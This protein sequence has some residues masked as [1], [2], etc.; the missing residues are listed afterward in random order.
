MANLHVGA[1]TPLLLSITPKLAEC[2]PYLRLPTEPRTLWVD[3]ICINQQDLEERKHQV[4]R[5]ANIYKMAKRVVVWLGPRENDSTLALRTLE[6]L[7]TKIDVDWD[8]WTMKSSSQEIS[9][10]HWGDLDQ[11][12]PY[13][14]HTKT[15]LKAILDRPWFQRL[16]VQQ[17][18][19]LANDAI[20]ADYTKPAGQ[21]YQETVQWYIEGHNRL[22]ILT[23]CNLSTKR[24]ETPSWVPNFAMPRGSKTL[25]DLNADSKTSR[26]AQIL[27]KLLKAKGVIGATVNHAE[28][29]HSPSSVQEFVTEVRR[30]APAG[31]GNESYIG[32]GT[33]LEAFASTIYVGEFSSSWIP[34]EES[35]L[36]FGVSVEHLR[37]ILDPLKEP[38][39]AASSSNMAFYA[40]NFDWNLRGRAFITTR[41]GFIG[42]A[43]AGVRPEDQIVVLLGCRSPLV[44]RPVED[45]QHLVVGECYVPGLLEG[46]SLLGPLP[47]GYRLVNRYDDESKRYWWAFVNEDTRQIEIEDPRLGNLPSGWQRLIHHVKDLYVNVKTGEISDPRLRP[48]ALISRGVK[49]RDFY[50]T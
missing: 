12:F 30:L 3:A 40:G 26:S 5:M 31:T 18:I 19:R 10:L 23:R 7:A 47:A 28:T 38:L 1:H 36:E 43:P 4:Q 25:I 14:A 13:Q 27:G 49:G 45:R 39:S 17:E 35:F 22:D 29:I 32:G 50:I 16:W 34:V 24:T 9:E 42:A 46:E 44:L 20:F 41:E 8:T 6:S 2:L 15:A 21:V 37:H 11:Q 33:T 48:D